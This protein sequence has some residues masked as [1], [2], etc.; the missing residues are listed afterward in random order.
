MK[1]EHL[2]LISR[3]GLVKFEMPLKTDGC[4][5]WREPPWEEKEYFLDLKVFVHNLEV[6]SGYPVFLT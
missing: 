2:F 5:H 1:G 6:V 3:K 4:F